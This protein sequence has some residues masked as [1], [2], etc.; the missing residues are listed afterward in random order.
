[1]CEKLETYLYLP[2]EC[3]RLY[4][5][6]H[7]PNN[8]EHIEWHGRVSISVIISLLLETLAKHISFGSE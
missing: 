8:P 7:K 4:S 1:M 3:V 6:V 2:C 5:Y